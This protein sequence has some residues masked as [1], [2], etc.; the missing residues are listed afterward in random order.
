[1]STLRA[2][3]FGNPAIY[4]NEQKLNFPFAKMEAMLYFLLV[5]GE[6]TR[7]KLAT[8]FWGDMDENSA[9]KNLRNTIY[10]IKKIMSNSLLITPTRTTIAVNPKLIDSTDVALLDIMEI[11]TFLDTYQGVFLD[12]FYCKNTDAFDEWVM[13]ERERFKEKVTVRLTE[14]IVKRMNDKDYMAAKQSIKQLIKLDEYNES[15]YRLLMKIYEREEAFYKVIEIY[16]E[17][18]K[19]LAEDLKLQPSSKTREIYNR[20]REKRMIT[21]KV[22]DAAKEDGFF[23]RDKELQV[24][25]T[26]V[27]HFCL[28]RHK[29]P[30]MFVQG[31]QGIGKT[32]TV[33]RL[34]TSIPAENCSVL[35]TQ[36]YQAEAGYDYKSWSNI[37]IQVKNLLVRDKIA[38][39]PLW[40]KVLSYIFP[41]LEWSDTLTGQESF[42]VAY[43]FNPTMVEEIMCGV[44][45]KLAKQR[46]LIIVID[47]IHWMDSQSLAV[48]HQ[49]LRL[50]GSEIFC[51]AL[52]HSEY[53]SHIEKSLWDFERDD[54]LEKVMLERFDFETVGRILESKLP[55][56]KINDELKHKLYEYTGGN[57]LFLM[58]CLHLLAAGR[59]LGSGSLRLQSVLKERLGNLSAN[60]RKILEVASVFFKYS[61][62]NELL[63]IS[64]VDEFALVE[65]IE[66]LERKRLITKTDH[67][68]PKGLVYT[69]YNL[70]IQ[71]FVYQQM[72]I[73]RRKLLHK[74]VGL[75]LERQVNNGQQ[76]KDIY[77]AILYHYTQADEKIKVIAYT[78]K[79]AEKYFCPQYELFPELNDCYPAGYSGFRESR[80]QTVVYL[81]KIRELLAVM[82]AEQAGDG[83]VA[84]Y[85]SAYW[86]MMGRYYIWRGEHAAGI[87]MIHQLLRLA[88]DKGFQDY[89]VKG[90]Q[91]MIFLGI[92]VSR[93]SIIKR[94]AEKLLDIAEQADL[95]GKKAAALRFLGLAAALCGQTEQAE[96][97]YRQSIA[98]FKK[99]DMQNNCYILNIAAAY[100]YI[101]NLRREALKLEEA[102]HYY[103]QAVKTAGHKRISEGVAVFYIN[104]GYTAFKLGII[105]KARQYLSD[106]QAVGDGFGEYRG[107]WCSRSYCT[108]YC[109]LAI[110]AVREKR[111]HEGRMYLHKADEFL[112]RYHD[113][114]QNGLVLQTK[115]EI[116]QAM[117]QNP[118]AADIFGDYLTLSAREYYQQ[119]KII[120]HK[121][122][123]ALERKS[124][125][126]VAEFF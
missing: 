36:C 45:G 124:L 25:R 23:G 72:S 3:M 86:E 21:A 19:R 104:A 110:I 35:R 125:D 95:P 54:M 98:L 38:I 14:S 13:L 80:H 74:L 116:R 59:E 28:K 64:K 40:Y 17:L 46:R 22:A 16:Q 101:G 30:M 27:A 48:L 83:Q 87:K 113:N 75:E 93:P 15:A 105:D 122:G 2:I 65:A 37:F 96:Q 103:E 44:L 58:E 78:V 49:V 99:M 56:E 53:F 31:E 41:A 79:L 84:I 52:C 1:M 24:L 60:A 12:G 6:T 90:Y 76:A 66:E 26:A 4:W 39:P 121:A 107:Y 123:G 106:A 61:S 29:H 8:M 117:D 5:A 20:V 43:E 42:M 118:V 67:I 119:A 32:T 88:S 82:A 73:P 92:Q 77:E 11:H 97:Y 102:L 9:K 69:F 57:A 51:I 115:T 33:E 10:L 111:Y 81:E 18:E 94:F 114:Y 50:H 100:N 34:F 126:E 62:Y 7:E 89:L 112:D 120:L 68:V 85:Q 55:A 47:D 71:S 70:Q 109:V 91:E 63:A 108:L